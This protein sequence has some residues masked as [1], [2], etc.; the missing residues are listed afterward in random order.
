M[1]P[2]PSSVRCRRMAGMREALIHDYLGV[3]RGVAWGI[4]RRPSS[5]A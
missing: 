2:A 5:R 3:D 1:R 4:C